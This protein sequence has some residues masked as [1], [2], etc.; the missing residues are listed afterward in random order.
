LD[1][2]SKLIKT[3]EY[4]HENI[5]EELR[6]KI[7]VLNTLLENKK[8]SEIEQPKKNKKNLDDGKIFIF[9][10]L[11]VVDLKLDNVLQKLDSFKDIFLKNELDKAKLQLKLEMNTKIED[12]EGEFLK[13]LNNTKKL[14]EKAIL[15]L[16][17]S[18]NEEISNL[19]Q[20]IKVINLP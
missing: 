8:H 19:K 4:S 2:K 18:Y 6:S 13:K 14:C 16:K 10:F 5:I 15:K 9:Y 17:S 3:S 7:H 12:V 20:L 1:E 11:G